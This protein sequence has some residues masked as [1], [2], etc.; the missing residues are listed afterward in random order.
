MKVWLIT[1]IQAIVLNSILQGIDRPNE[2][3]KKLESTSQTMTGVIDRLERSGFIERKRD[4]K[5]RRGVR[6]IPT[7][8]CFDIVGSPTRFA[9]KLESLIAKAAREAD[10]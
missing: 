10:H 6:L 1:G 9:K 5:D 8:T 4:I 7:Q 2:I 3:S